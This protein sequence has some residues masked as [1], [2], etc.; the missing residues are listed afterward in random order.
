MQYISIHLTHTATALRHEALLQFTCTFNFCRQ[1]S[2]V[3]WGEVQHLD[4][5]ITSELHNNLV[6]HVFRHVC[7]ISTVTEYRH[8]CP[9]VGMYWI[10]T[11]GWDRSWPPDSNMS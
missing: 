10:H 3:G 4:V 9:K 1:Y 6:L 11:A 2:C 5:C 8:V 7:I